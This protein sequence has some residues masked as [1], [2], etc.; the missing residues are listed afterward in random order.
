MDHKID[1]EE[2][3]N[4]KLKEVSWGLLYS[5]LRDEL[6]VLWKMLTELL[7]KEFI[8]VSN[9]SAATSILFIG[10][11]GGGLRFC[12]DYRGLNKIIKKN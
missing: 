10:K 2:G 7:D 5:I 4:S 12:V 8:C 1:L 6:L 11:P 9:S 3:D